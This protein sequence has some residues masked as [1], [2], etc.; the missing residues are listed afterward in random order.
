M[1]HGD[2]KVLPRRTTS[3]K[4]L[5]DKT[6]NVPKNLRYDW[7][8]RGLPSVVYNFFLIK[9]LLSLILQALLKVKLSK[10]KKLA[11]E[12][13]KPII[14]KFGKPKVNSSFK[15]NICGAD[16]VDKQLI[17]RLNKWFQLYIT[18]IYSKYALVFPLKDKKCIT[19]T[20][21][22]QETLDDSGHKPNKMWVKKEWEF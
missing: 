5:R 12:L 13:H 11:E 2:F 18:D 6:F 10:I 1:T 8:Q 3:D 15:D 19:I 20:N 14:R 17:S 4:V 7:Y 22:F 16:L 9:R 21:A